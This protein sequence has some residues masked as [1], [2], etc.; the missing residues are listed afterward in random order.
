M[1]ISPTSIFDIGTLTMIANCSD[2]TAKLNREVTHASVAAETG[3]TDGL[4]AALYEAQRHA[5]DLEC[6]LRSLMI[7]IRKARERT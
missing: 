5:A 3:N 7:T 4:M 1:S 2:A 6:V